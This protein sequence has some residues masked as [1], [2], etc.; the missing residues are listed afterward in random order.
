MSGTYKNIDSHSEEFVTFICKHF[1]EP[2][3]HKRNDVIIDIK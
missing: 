1:I 3:Q 2:V